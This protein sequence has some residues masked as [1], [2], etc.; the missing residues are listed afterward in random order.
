[1]SIFHRTHSDADVR[2]ARTVTDTAPA[3][4]A[5]TGRHVD[6]ALARAEAAHERYGGVNWGAAFFGWLVA[7]ALVVL[8]GG[9]VGA[10]ATAVGQSTG[11]TLDDLANDAGTTGLVGAIALVAVMLIGYYAGGYVAGRMSRFDG[12]R[13][14]AAVWLLGVVI[15]LVAAV[16]GWIFGSE[17]DV[18]QRVDLPNIDMPDHTATVGGVVT[19]AVVIVVTLFAAMVGGRLGQRYH[20]KVDRVRAIG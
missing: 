11:T 4:Q 2:D 20:T 18:M 15:T 1:M 5:R 14:G 17:Y 19:A 8:L 16:V 13:Q 12:A 10:V 7:I 9:I 3:D 6:P